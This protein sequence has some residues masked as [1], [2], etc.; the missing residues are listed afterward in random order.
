MDLNVG[1]KKTY[2]DTLKFNC[3]QKQN[4][5]VTSREHA[6]SGESTITASTVDR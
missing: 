1:R 5:I 2:F 3:E 4:T 6:K